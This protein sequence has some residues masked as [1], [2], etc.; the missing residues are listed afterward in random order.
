VYLQT[1]CP[2]RLSCV[3]H[4]V[5]FGTVYAWVLTGSSLTS[6]DF[7]GCS[8]GMLGQHVVSVPACGAWIV[9]RSELWPRSQHGPQYV[10]GYP[11]GYSL[12]WTN[13]RSRCTFKHPV[14]RVYHGVLLLAT[15]LAN[16]CCLAGCVG[17]A[18]ALF[19][20]RRLCFTVRC[21]VL[22]VSSHLEQALPCLVSG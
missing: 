8:A 12:F 5:W 20:I 15:L 22:L 2:S 6:C 18:V 1:P 16:T 17:F 21:Y 10:L 13:V 3:R 7:A 19:L 4:T 9:C 11:A 14:H